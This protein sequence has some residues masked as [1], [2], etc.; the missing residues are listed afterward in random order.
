MLSPTALNNLVN[1]D[2]ISPRI[3]LI[4]LQ[5]NPKTTIICAYSPQNSR[6]VE[7]VEEFV[8]VEVFVDEVVL[9]DVDV[10]LDVDVL[11]DVEV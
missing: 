10:L 1:V 3:L 5:G 8:E 4:E 9:D 7:E 6:P 11:V 2:P